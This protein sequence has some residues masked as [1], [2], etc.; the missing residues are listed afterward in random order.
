MGCKPALNLLD[1]RYF[2]LSDSSL[3]YLT[4]NSGWEIG[5]GPSVVV[6]VKGVASAI[7]TTTAREEIYAFFFDQGGL[8]LGL[9]LQGTKI[10]K[11]TPDE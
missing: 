7:T 8:M 5:T 11:I 3:E 4:N 9:G 2:F 1:M 6:V 10:S